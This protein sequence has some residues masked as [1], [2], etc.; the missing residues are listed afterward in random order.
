MSA[1]KMLTQF[2]LT[3][4]HA[5][6]VLIVPTMRIAAALFISSLSAQ[7]SQT[8]WT[9]LTVM[10]T[11]SAQYPQQQWSPQSHQSSEH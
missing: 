5:G 3:T 9:V 6:M 10:R 1:H 8:V 2:A 11:A 4:V 7:C